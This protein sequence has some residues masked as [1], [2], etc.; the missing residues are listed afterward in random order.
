MNV[1]PCTSDL[2]PP[3]VPLGARRPSLRTL[4][5]LS[6]FCIPNSGTPWVFSIWENEQV[7]SVN[8][9]PH[10][11]P[12]LILVMQRPVLHPNTHYAAKGVSRAGE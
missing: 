5:Y 6:P 12:L 10:Y 4:S 8:N 11:Y 3:V 1:E 2:C 9:V 7:H